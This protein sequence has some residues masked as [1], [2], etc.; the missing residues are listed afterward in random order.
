M[1][2]YI[3]NNLNIILFAARMGDSYVC[4]LDE[5]SV[6]KA[7]ERTERDSVRPYVG[8]PGSEGL[9][10]TAAAP[11]CARAWYSQFFLNFLHNDDC[12]IK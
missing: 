7:K 3:Y 5:A 9:G 12:E 2:S 11:Q 10:H 4:T 1:I 8:H 6:K